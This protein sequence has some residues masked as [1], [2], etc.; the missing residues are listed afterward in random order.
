MFCLLWL[1]LIDVSLQMLA[2][3]LRNAMAARLSLLVGGLIAL[4]LFLWLFGSWRSA[5]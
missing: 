4:A 5:T 3:K 2:R 1:L